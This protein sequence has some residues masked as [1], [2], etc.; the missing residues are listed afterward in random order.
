MSLSGWGNYPTI[1]SQRFDFR[2]HDDLRTI[3]SEHHD[4]I[5]RG[6]GRSYGD[7]SLSQ[8]VIDVKPHDLFLDFDEDNGSL[9]VQAGVLLSQILDVFVPRGWFLKITPG[10]KLITVGGAIASDVH[11]K[12]HHVSGCF[13]ECVEMFHLMLP[14]GNVVQ[15]SKIVN[16]ELFRATC[17][18]MGLTG[19]ILDARILLQKIGSAS[20]SQTTVKARDLEETFEAFEQHEKARFSVAW[21][22]CFATSAEMGRSLLTI[23][24][25]KNDGALDYRSRKKLNV[26]RGFPAFMTNKLSAKAFNQLYYSRVRERESVQTV[27]I[28]TF[29]YPLDA[30]DNWNRVYGKS[31]FIQYNFVL[32]KGSS[33]AGLK[34][35]LPFRRE[36]ARASPFR[37]QS[38]GQRQSASPAR[39]AGRPDTG[40]SRD[41][42]RP[43]P[44]SG[45]R[46]LRRSHSRQKRRP[47]LPGRSRQPVC[48]CGNRCDPVRARRGRDS[49]ESSALAGLRVR[50]RGRAREGVGHLDFRPAKAR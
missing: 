26:P 47:V 37:N 49:R 9:H 35:V 2:Q 16:T 19:V 24:E 38:P 21:I 25:F 46:A 1:Q 42:N 29:F 20:L 43:S 7:S 41:A 28:D 30:I 3:I 44:D 15:C 50:R 17:G 12:N 11:G 33:H 27:G 6:N 34:E 14:D 22:D 4:L 48:P 39:T 45:Q 13:S 32:P 8:N 18:G 36:S 23:G 10:T 40:C 5:P 31:G